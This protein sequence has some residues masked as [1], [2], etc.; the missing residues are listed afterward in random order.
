MM[1]TQQ[2]MDEADIRRRMDKWAE[3]IRAMDVDGVMSSYAAD[4]VCVVP[5]AD[6]STG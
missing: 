3:A 4:V 6:G 1:T 2:T 5:T